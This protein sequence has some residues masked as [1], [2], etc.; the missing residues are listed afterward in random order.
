MSPTTCTSCGSPLPAVPADQRHPEWCATCAARAAG[1][2]PAGPP[3]SAPGPGWVPASPGG[4]GPPAPMAPMGPGVL[5]TRTRPLEAILLGVAAATIAGIAWWAA[6]ATTKQQFVYG[7]VV[8]GI[9]VGQAVLIGARK[10]GAGP[11]A[12]AIVA[13]LAALVVAEYFI[14]R[15]LAIDN[16]HADLPL[17]MGFSTAREVVQEAV[18]EHPLTAVFWGISAV[19]AAVSAGSSTRRPI[20]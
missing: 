16:F 6:V 9:L 14:Q 19:L 8:V 12:I 13:S 1:A 4:F 18:K 15:S 3:P 10:G 7:A 11:A 20:V 2:I 5:V 17:W